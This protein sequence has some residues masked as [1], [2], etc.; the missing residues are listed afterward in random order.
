[1]RDLCPKQIRAVLL[2]LALPAFCLLSAC[3]GPTG[4]PGGQGAPSGSDTGS[5]NQGG[6]GGS[7][8]AS[9]GGVLAETEHVSANGAYQTSFQIPVPPAP[10]APRVSLNYDSQAQGALAG[11]GW[12]FSVGYP[13][14]IM[15]DVRFGTPQWKFNAN[16]LWGS[17]PLVRLNPTTCA[18]K[19]DY[20]TAPESLVS[21]TIDLS[22]PFPDDGQPPPPPRER[23]TVHLPNGTT[24]DYEPI[25]YDGESYP[26]APAGADTSVFGF[27]L[28][29]VTDRNGYKACFKYREPESQQQMDEQRN[30]GRVAPLEQVTYGPSRSDLRT[31]DCNMIFAD[32]NWRQDWHHIDIEN[33]T[34]TDHTLTD[35]SYFSS[36]TLRF[37]APVKFNDLVI[38]ISLYVRGSSQPQDEY[39]LEYYPA[40]E[41]ETRRP[42][43]KTIG[44]RVPL[45]NADAQSPFNTT[46][47]TVRAFKY[48]RRS[49][50]YGTPQIV[51]IGTLGSVPASLAGSV[52]RPIRR[53]SPFDNPG[54]LFQVG[55]DQDSD[56]APLSH[57]TTE[58]WAF[59][60][61]N[62][63]GL[64]DIQWGKEQG[65]DGGQW[66]FET[67]VP[68]AP[69]LVE[70]PSSLAVPGRPAFVPINNRPAEQKI[71]INNGITDSRRT[72]S[73]SA[74]K[75]QAS[76]L[77]RDYVPVLTRRDTVP[78]GFTSWLWGEGRGQTRTG[79]PVAISAPEIANPA[80]AC[81]RN[82]DTDPR[83]WP[84]YPDGSIAIPKGSISAGL[85]ELNL[86]G[87]ANM[88]DWGDPI[89]KIVK[90]IHD[91]YRPTF[92][93]S[94][95]VSA[96]AD[97]DGD[98]IPEFI[99]TPGWIE[100]FSLDGTCLPPCRSGGCLARRADTYAGRRVRT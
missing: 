23:A 13:M 50:D 91:G 74:I 3:G 26:A 29:S 59:I 19:C 100:R 65:F 30:F 21:V 9:T 70:D 27:R 18:D 12:D 32:Q 11:V 61:I 34:L 14:S 5:T 64:P 85:L 53:E 71:V 7:D 81:P 43:L 2:G 16:W 20:R 72:T 39:I 93:V 51:A 79:M 76:S 86:A 78:T 62:G 83:R 40:S 8:P 6:P 87:P 10:G 47:K 44:H 46:D 68:A 1:M 73:A 67:G 57:A 42:L 33:D 80:I 55:H 97:L 58:Q 52:T 82:S 28:Y 48:G 90:G 89:L 45:P 36:W 31:K 56:A 94:A 66:T 63:D 92:S 4:D 37:G 38:K 88:F 69:V 17:T 75:F 84:L 49:P 96:W 98:G 60:D 54:G 99:A 77:E 35:Q 24:L 41:T 15:R 22:N 25:Y 95:S